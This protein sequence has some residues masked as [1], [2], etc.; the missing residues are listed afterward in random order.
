MVVQPRISEAEMRIRS[1]YII[2]KIYMTKQICSCLFPTLLT[3]DYYCEKIKL[4]FSQT[5]FFGL[6]LT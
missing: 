4:Y 3:C 6:E 2:K 5:D 1:V